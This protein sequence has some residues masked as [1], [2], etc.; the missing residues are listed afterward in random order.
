MKEGIAF[1]LIGSISTTRSQYSGVLSVAVFPTNSHAYP[2]PVV[3]VAFLLPP[4]DCGFTK[5]GVPCHDT[6]YFRQKGNIQCACGGSSAFPC[7]VRQNYYQN[8]LHRDHRIKSL[9]WNISKPRNGLRLAG[10][11]RSIPEIPVRLLIA[12]RSFPRTHIG[13]LV[14]STL[15]C[16]R[17]ARSL[18][19][20]PSTHKVAWA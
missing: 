16:N 8:M 20:G 18:T 5:D 10:Q 6:P 3:S 14:S 13:S 17:I 9:T 19:L 12:F 4:H 15:R 1:S 7:Q 2:T 11:E